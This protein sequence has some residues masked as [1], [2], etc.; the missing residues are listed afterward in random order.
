MSQN[1]RFGLSPFHS[2]GVVSLWRYWYVGFGNLDP[3]K[4]NEQ[5]VLL[6]NLHRTKIHAKKY[7]SLK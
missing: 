3:L 4:K 2:V 7:S 1:R 6:S 5:I